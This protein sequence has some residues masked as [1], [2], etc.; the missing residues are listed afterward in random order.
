MREQCIHGRR[1][2]RRIDPRY[3]T[4]LES[5]PDRSTVQ[6]QQVEGRVDA[7]GVGERHPCKLELSY[8]VQT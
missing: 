7:S 8:R 5:E 4:K 3:R 6:G 1:A 2:E